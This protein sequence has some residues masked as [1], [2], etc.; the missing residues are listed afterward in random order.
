MTD[1]LGAQEQI[2][3]LLKQI[4]PYRFS[5]DQFNIPRNQNLQQMMN[6]LRGFN[7]RNDERQDQLRWLNFA[8]RGKEHYRDNPNNPEEQA[9]AKDFANT[10]R[11]QLPESLQ[12]LVSADTPYAQAVANV[13]IFKNGYPRDLLRGVEETKN[14]WGNA[15]YLQGKTTDPAEIQRLEQ[16][17]Q[18]AHAKA[19]LYR[20]E[21]ERQGNPIAEDMTLGDV[22]RAIQARDEQRKFQTEEWLKQKG[23]DPSFGYGSS[24]FD[25]NQSR[26]LGRQS[27]GSEPGKDMVNT[28]FEMGQKK[29]EQVYLA[30]QRARDTARRIIEQKNRYESAQQ[31][32]NQAVEALNN[33]NL[34]AEQ[35]AELTALRDNS[36]I[37][38]QDANE[39]AEM[40]RRIAKENGI[41]LTGF[42]ANDTIKQSEENLMN[43]SLKAIDEVYHGKFGKSSGQFFEE[44]YQYY[45]KQGMDED[46]AIRL[47]GEEG[48]MYKYMKIQYMRDVT[49]EVINGGRI[50]NSQQLAWIAKLAEEDPMFAQMLLNGNVLPGEQF[51]H[52]RDRKETLQDRALDEAFSNQQLALK[53]AFAEKL[54]NLNQENTVT[55]KGIDQ[56]NALERMQYAAEINARIQEQN[57]KWQERMRNQDRA[58]EIRMVDVRN[59]SQYRFGKQMLADK[60]F[61][62]DE[63]FRKAWT[64]ISYGVDEDWLKA[65]GYE[66]MDDYYR[67]FARMYYGISDANRKAIKNSID[68]SYSKEDMKVLN[69]MNSYMNDLQ[70]AYQNGNDNRAKELFEDLYDYMQSDDWRESNIEV[71]E[72]SLAMLQVVVGEMYKSGIISKEEAQEILY[73]LPKKEQVKGTRPNSESPEEESTNEQD[74]EEDESNDEYYVRQTVEEFQKDPTKFEPRAIPTTQGWGANQYNQGQQIQPQSQNQSGT[75][76]LNQSGKSESTRI[77]ENMLKVLGLDPNGVNSY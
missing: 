32:Y 22:R 63:D 20:A 68:S 70:N 44:R 53:N 27:L 42:T 45:K 28:Y 55:N 46:T 2:N 57:Q 43:E 73:E 1:L 61:M 4:D 12:R 14:A 6:Y 7:E 75:N 51:T 16:E 71:K 77:W 5:A 69:Q 11:G 47:A 52:D 10:A 49:P 54:L 23:L 58:H 9:F 64:R 30:D 76:L 37:I 72:M 13:D 29:A 62:E 26:L 67:D 34:T 18:I 3:Q 50:E 31:S 15:N 17:K 41:N 35:R 24:G 74:D 33:P 66:S 38:M 19:N 60:R 65:H 21:S 36:M 39:K 59:D 8:L 48:T 40:T 56:Q 25:P